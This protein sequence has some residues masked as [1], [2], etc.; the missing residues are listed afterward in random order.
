MIVP[1]VVLSVVP[2]VVLYKDNFCF[3]S[4]FFPHIFDLRVVAIYV[5]CILT[6][7]AFDL[8]DLVGQ[9]ELGILGSHPGSHEA[10]LQ[11]GVA[12]CVPRPTLVLGIADQF[13]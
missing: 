6:N 2:T 1:T 8:I 13:F 12:Q 4:H 9:I 10:W 11:L 3:F 5:T 7:K